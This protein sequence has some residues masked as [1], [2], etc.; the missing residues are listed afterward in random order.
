MHA[1]LKVSHEFSRHIR[2]TDEES[3]WQWNSVHPFA[4]PA[5]SPYYCFCLLRAVVPSAEPA[6]GRFHFSPG[7]RS[8]VSRRRS[9][10]GTH[11]GHQPVVWVFSLFLRSP[12]QQ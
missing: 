11:V 9:G 3:T 12:C 1:R 7:I 2:I 6:R 10:D 8:L 4:T 5:H